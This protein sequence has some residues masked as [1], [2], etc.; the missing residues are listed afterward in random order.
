MPPKGASSYYLQIFMALL[1]MPSCN[2]HIK[3]NER[4]EC[5]IIQF[6]LNNGFLTKEGF[7]KVPVSE[8]YLVVKG[9]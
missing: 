8:I 2:F 9:R 1:E 7:K 5:S 4:F 3:K 6:I